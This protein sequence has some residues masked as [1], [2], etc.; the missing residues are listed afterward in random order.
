MISLTNC[1]GFAPLRATPRDQNGILTRAQ[2]LKTPL[3]NWLNR[4]LLEPLLAMLRQGI[5]PRRLALCVAVAIVI[6]NIPILGVSTILCTFI[7]L[8]FRLNFPAIQIVQAAMA[9]TQILLIIPFVRLGEWILR[10]PPQVVSVKAALT[11]MSQGLWQAVVVLRDAIFH[12]GLAWGLVA[13][14]A[15]YLLHRLLT[16]VFERM[17]AQIRRPP[18]EA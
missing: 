1:S 4:M 9:P 5:S 6:G 13:P 10:V 2:S 7:A 12:A 8:I 11:L 18:V 3:K 17:A 14:F 15:I 16:P